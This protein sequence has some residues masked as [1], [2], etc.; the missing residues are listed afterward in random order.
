MRLGQ[1]DMQ[2]QQ[3][4]LGTKTKHRQTEGHRAPERCQVLLAHVGKGVVSG[5][6]LQQAK[7]QQDTQGTNVRH[8]HVDVA[9]AANLG[10]AV[11]G[12]HQK[13]R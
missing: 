11:V 7:T 13:E 9:S 1:P 2:G 6:G 5:V 10:N 12:Q 4:C 8:Q 3:T